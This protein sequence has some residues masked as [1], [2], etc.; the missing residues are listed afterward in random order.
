[1]L[2]IDSSYEQLKRTDIKEAERELSV[3]FPPE[4]IEFLMRRNGGRPFPDGVRVN[5]EHFD[6]VGFL[7]AIREDSNHDDLEKNVKAYRGLI[8]DYY[9]PF[10]ESP[11][12]DVYCLALRSEEFGAVYHWNHYEYDDEVEPSEFNMTKLAGSFNEFIE[13]LYDCGTT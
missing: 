4:Y 6:F 5:G 7:Y 10:G 11:G 8:L 12:G 9:L 13:G 1:M 2:Q 3:E